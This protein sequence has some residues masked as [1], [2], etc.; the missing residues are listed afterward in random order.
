MT[1]AATDP[2][3][4]STLRRIAATPAFWLAA[5]C[6]AI[7]L[8]ANANYDVFRDELYF[9]VC[10]LHPAFGYVDQPPLIPLIAAASFKLFGTALTPLR[11]V[12][13][14]A[15]AATVALTADFA[16]RLGG[17]R[18]AQ[19]LAGLCVLQAP[20]LLAFGVLLSTDCLQPL[21]W[22]ACAWILLRLIDSGD[23][24]WWLAFG[25][26]VGVSFESKYL[27]AFYAV[28]LAI[29]I[30]AT[31]LRRSLMR[32][33]I[34]AGAALALAIAL[35]NILWQATHGWPFLEVAGADVGAKSVPRSP[36]GFLLQ[37]ALFIGPV[38][39]LVWLAG[40]WRLAIRPPRPELRALAIAYVV[41][42]TIF[43]VMRGK[44]YYLTPIYPALFA[45][46]AVARES[47]LKR[48]VTRGVVIAIIVIAGLVT[49]PT[50]LPILPPDVLIAYMQAIGLSP[51]A[52]Q[53]ES[54][55]LA[56]LPQYYA[57]M[58]GWREMA[59]AV[60]TVY[61]ELPPED[62]AQA[63]FF[64]SNYGEAAA[65]DI[66]GSPLGGPPVISGHNSYFLWGPQGAS[67]KVVIALAHDSSRFADAYKDIRAAGRIENA[68][69]MPYESG[70]TIW[71]L[72]E[73]SASLTDMWDKL[74]HYD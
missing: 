25:A 15:S 49:A 16:R 55:K 65:L 14:L 34:W 63:V 70:L 42:F 46:G 40:L 11:L 68:Y 20:V 5:V 31:P 30:L 19:I 17:G 32:P 60:S 66:Y 58:F 39:A 67:G 6:L 36:L 22:L 23:E 71:V 51:K 9:I 28:A 38:S 56:A 57:D 59:A 10:G 13:A 54:M 69:A 64:A 26:V 61:R 8:V 47:W 7:H 41:A 27:I 50:V 24:R 43:V 3:T 4:A 12:P 2:S 74:K 52:T 35:P 73:P 18:F 29:G 45:A 53:T 21:S 37:Q 48:P 62:R 33:W 1:A 44:A 72:R